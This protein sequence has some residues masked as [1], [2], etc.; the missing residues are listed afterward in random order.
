M[1]ERMTDALNRVSLMLRGMSMDPAIP[2]HAKEVMMDRVVEIES[3]LEEAS[4][5]GGDG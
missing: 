3:L 2:A 5:E 1:E 4:D